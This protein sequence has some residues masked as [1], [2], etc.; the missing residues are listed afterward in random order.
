MTAAE[1]NITVADLA[2]EVGVSPATVSR[3]LNHS[4]LVSQTTYDKV[5]EAIDR[6]GYEMPEQREIVVRKRLDSNIVAVNIS[7]YDDGTHLEYLKGVHTSAYR[8]EWVP[9]LT[10]D[11]LTMRT[12]DQYVKT[13][14]RMRVAA[15]LVLNYVE[16][17]VLDIIGAE[18]PVVQC[19][20]YNAMAPYPYV[21]IDDC[22]AA[23]SAVSHLI[24]RGA[25]RVALV[26]A[27]SSF[28]YAR[29]RRRGYE[30][31][32][33]GA[34]IEYNPAYVIELT[35]A[36]FAMAH[37]FVS[38]MLTFQNRPDA[39]FA[40]N[41]I[42]AYAAISAAREQGF[43]VPEDISVSGFGN[44]DIS[45]MASPK[46]TTVGQPRFQMGFV[47]CELLHEQWANPSATTQNIILNT[48]LVIRGST[49]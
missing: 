40:T 41:D 24:S 5:I 30:Q 36:S 1:K 28:R 25:R 29:E 22:T 4:H 48:E 26:N 16:R 14:Q 6:L 45:I 17:D 13:L 23:R 20:E 35:E 49:R 9:V 12:V 18:I 8:Y 3:V 38:P 43:T 32:L 31:A 21:G 42:M 10:Q 7:T 46:I 39:I 47:A 27:S 37:A 19:A 2:K 33:R 34:G 44:R 11:P 15:L